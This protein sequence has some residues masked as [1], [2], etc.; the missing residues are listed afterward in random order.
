MINLEV[1]YSNLSF[2]VYIALLYIISPLYSTD[3]YS[4]SIATVVWI[5]E[6]VLGPRN[7]WSVSEEKGTPHESGHGIGLPQI[8][9]LVH[10]F[11]DVL[12]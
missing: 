10:M 12:K 6:F 4:T 11:V 1:F 3:L 5:F 8:H 9:V 7:K 2:W